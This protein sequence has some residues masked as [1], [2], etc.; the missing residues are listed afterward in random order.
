MVRSPTWSL[1]GGVLCL[2]SHHFGWMPC[3]FTTVY[4]STVVRLGPDLPG[5]ELLLASFWFGAVCFHNGNVVPLQPDMPVL[6]LLYDVPSILYLT[7]IYTYRVLLPLQAPLTLLLCVAY[8][9]CCYSSCCCSSSCA[10]WP[11]CLLVI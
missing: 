7:C 2:F 5:I 6:E 1:L 10:G 4:S 9:C 11:K 8:C 3:G